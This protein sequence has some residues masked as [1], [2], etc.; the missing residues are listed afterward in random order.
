MTDAAYDALVIGAGHNG[1]ACASYLAASGRSVL[2]LEA[3]ERPGGLARTREFADGFRVSAGAH[4]LHM[5]DARVARELA[6]EQQGLAYAARNLKTVAL[7]DNG[8]RVVIDGA[9]LRGVGATDQVAYGAFQRQNRRFAKV[10]ADFCARPLPRLVERGRGDTLALARLAWKLRTLGKADMRELLRV[11]AINIY[12]VAQEKFDNRLLKAA[13]G[14]DAVL[15]SHMGPRSPNTVFTYLHRHMN[16][17]GGAVGPAIVKG[18]M[19]A[20]GDAFAAAATAS[21]AEIRYGSRVTRIHVDRLGPQNDYGV[22]AV[23]LADGSRIAAD[24]VVSNADLKSTCALVGPLN[25]DAGFARRVYNFRARGVAAKLHLAL[26]GLPEFRGLDNE[27][28]GARLLLA[29]SMEDIE[30]AFD[31]AKYGEFSPAPV[32]EV[33]IPTLWDD[34]LAP[35]GKH[36]LS[37]VAQYA[38]YGLKGGWETGRAAFKDICLKRLEGFA[39]GIGSLVRA[40]ELLAPPDLEAEFGV[41]GGHWHH[42]EIALD[43][44]LFTRPVPGANRYAMPVPGLYLCGASNHPGGGILGLAGRNAA[45]EIIAREGAR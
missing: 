15:G 5:L 7:G 33:S 16:D 37:A 4:L 38:P 28:M 14:M 43:Q 2:V 32:M 20:L 36:V 30:A 29:V 11:G 24:L 1:L 31:H 13:L 22:V 35:A 45:K 44:A 26:D 10:L 12:D 40:A 34:S 39:P 3:A 25:L 42:G 8:E 41:W 6:L 19:G 21:G 23:T 17:G 27:D 18:G 9:A